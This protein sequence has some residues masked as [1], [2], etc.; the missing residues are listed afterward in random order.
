MHPSR[1]VGRFE[2]DNFS[3]RPGDCGRYPMRNRIL[4]LFL[5]AM[6]VASCAKQDTVKAPFVPKIGDSIELVYSKIATPYFSYDFHEKGKI[7]GYLYLESE[8]RFSGYGPGMIDE[9]DP[10]VQVFLILF[11]SNMITDTLMLDG[12]VSD[13]ILDGGAREI[14]EKRLQPSN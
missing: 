5:Y 4:P 6:L 8:E 12:P 13:E 7:F 1:E 2:M 11:E 9:A 14:F 3:S 10:E